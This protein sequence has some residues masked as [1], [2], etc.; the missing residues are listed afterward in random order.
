[1]QEL[2]VGLKKTAPDVEKLLD[3]LFSDIVV[4]S[5]E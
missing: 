5:N 4:F 3:E 1:V 2:A